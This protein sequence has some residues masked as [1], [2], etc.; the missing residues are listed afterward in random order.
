MIDL[1]RGDFREVLAGEQWD[2]TIMDGPYGPRTHKA[3]DDI[4][5]SDD[6]DRRPISY[7]YWTPL[8]VF[9]A[10]NFLAPRT[11]SWFCSMTSHDLIQ[12]WEE[13]LEHH[14]LY[15]FAP[16]PVRTRPRVRLQGDGPGSSCC[17]LVVARPREK[18]FIGW[19][20][21]PGDYLRSSGDIDSL[22]MGGKPLGVMRRIVAD[23]SRQGDIIC[24]P[25]AGMATTLLAAESIGRRA[26]GAEV[27]PET[28]AAALE[29]IRGGNQLAL[30]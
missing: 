12:A 16:I 17:F 13:A 1:R 8:H 5:H 25:T 30:V 11:R 2:H 10:V 27:D 4:D 6:S 22:I 23:Y 18:R 14:G 28:Y 24:D 19:G 9:D 3:G 26:I 29:R 21:L 7:S 20:A 15:A